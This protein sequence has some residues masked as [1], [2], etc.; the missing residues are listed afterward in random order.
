MEKE[1]TIHRGRKV[2]S[3]D[4]K[5][6]QLANHM[7]KEVGRLASLIATAPSLDIAQS[8]FWKIPQEILN[9]PAQFALMH[10][11]VEDMKGVMATS[12]ARIKAVGKERTRVNGTMGGT[13]HP[14]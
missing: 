3:L 4:L 2:Q 8:D 5:M 14:K 1:A 12:K 7:E 13:P 11:Q 10:K 9:L 6:T